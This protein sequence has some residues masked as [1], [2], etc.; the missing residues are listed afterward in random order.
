MAVVTTKSSQITNRDANP[1]AFNN[2]RLV[3]ANLLISSG[4]VSAVSGDSIASKYIF[5]TVP[6]NALISK[7]S[8]S[9][10]DIGTTGTIDIG[11]Y[12]TTDNG[13]AVVDADFIASAVVLNAGA[14]NSIIITN[15]S[16]VYTVANMEKPLWEAL[17]L[18]S[19]PKRDYD[20]V[21][22]LTAAQDGSGS[23]FL[24]IAYTV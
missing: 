4:L 22:T 6:S 20:V 16:G 18:T 3:K 12:Q 14:L 23:I 8:I 10:P 17:G 11:I 5:T 19:D 1:K 2:G 9:C 13:S 21:G 15:E 7:V 24:A